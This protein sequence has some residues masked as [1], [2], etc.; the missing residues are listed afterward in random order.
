[1]TTI[2]ATISKPAASA[3]STV[4]SCSPLHFRPITVEMMPRV[5]AY[6]EREP[7]RT[8]DF[9]YGGLLM[10]VDLFH[11]ESCIY[12]DTLFIKGRQENDLIHT[13]FS[14]PVGS[15]PLSRSVELLRGYCREQRLPLRFSAIPEYAVPLFSRLG[16]RNISPQPDWADYLYD[17]TRLATLT[18]KAMAKKRNH[19]NRYL[20]LYGADTFEIVTPANLPDLY[21]FMSQLEQYPAPSTAAAIERRLAFN[22]LSL[23]CR[24][25]VPL[26]A[27]LLRVEGRVVAFT[28]GDVK[29]DTLYIH[30]EKALRDVSGAYEMIN[31]AF[32][33]QMMQQ[34]PGLRFINRED[35]AGDVGLRRAKMSYHPLEILMKYDIEE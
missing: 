13:A 29:G 24:P 16:F 34:H 32:A 31:Y 20:K 35:D 27:G 3:V 25:D 15:L 22:T 17:A 10:W 26:E 33:R 2:T 14:L 18:G 8:C 19:V 1:M 21:L 9:S 4:A 23:L 11:Y 28:V 12:A 5:L 30:I 6:L 7:G